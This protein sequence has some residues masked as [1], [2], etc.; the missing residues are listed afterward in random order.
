MTKAHCQKNET[1]KMCLCYRHQMFIN[2]EKHHLVINPY[3]PKSSK[4]FITQSQIIR[5]RGKFLMFICNTDLEK[6]TYKNNYAF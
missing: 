2:M 4:S 5:T 3:L 1:N 6:S